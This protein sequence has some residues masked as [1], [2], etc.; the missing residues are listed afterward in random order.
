M[1]AM[2]V[3]RTSVRLM[4]SN[5]PSYFYACNEMHTKVAHKNIREQ[6][7]CSRVSARKIK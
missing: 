1:H 4:L 3:T 2:L 7:Y 6:L 5:V